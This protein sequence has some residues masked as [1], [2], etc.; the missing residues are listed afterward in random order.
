MTGTDVVADPLAAAWA[1]QA[2]RQAEER[3]R[4]RKQDRM[5]TLWALSREDARTGDPVELAGRILPH[6]HQGADAGETAETIRE[7]Q[8]AAAAPPLLTA[9]LPEVVEKVLLCL[10]DGEDG[11]FSRW[12]RALVSQSRRLR[13]STS[14][15]GLTAIEEAALAAA[16][17]VQDGLP[18]VGWA[19]P[20]DR[21]EGI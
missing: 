19:P 9:P 4:L 21:G 1:R 14:V 20:D 3:V 6:L 17:L 5:N 13:G 12:G 11:T 15:D 7:W 8:H 16:A 10:V 2:E 18:L